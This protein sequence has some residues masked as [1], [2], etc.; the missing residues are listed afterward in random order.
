[1]QLFIVLDFILTPIGVEEVSFVFK[2]LIW[3][4]NGLKIGVSHR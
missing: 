1:M 3:N 4:Q 2:Y